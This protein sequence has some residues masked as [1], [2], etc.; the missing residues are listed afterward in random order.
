MTKPKEEIGAITAAREAL[1]K[2]ARLG[3]APMM[4]NSNANI[5]AQQALKGL[6]DMIAGVPDEPSFPATM[7]SLKDVSKFCSKA[8]EYAVDSAK[9]LN[10]GLRGWDG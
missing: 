10:D 8:G 3:N 2:L 1:D 6:E 9:I 7:K 4:G 5:I